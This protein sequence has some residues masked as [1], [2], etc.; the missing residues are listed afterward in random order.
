M[1]LS[2]TDFAS[3]FAELLKTL[4]D[5][6]AE[7]FGAGM[8]DELLALVPDIPDRA[9]EARLFRELAVLEAKR[10]ELTCLDHAERALAAHADTG[11]LSDH[12]LY[13]MHLTCGDVGTAWNGGPRTA[14]HL[15]EALRLHAELGRPLAEAFSLRLNRG[16]HERTNGTARMGLDWFEPLLA[17][18]EREYG[19]DSPYLNHLLGLM[20][21]SEEKMGNMPGALA[22][23]ERALTL[24]DV[25]SDM[26]RRVSAL[27]AHAK[28]QLRAGY[29]D[30]AR[31]L[32]DE[33]ITFADAH[34]SRATQEFAREQ[35]AK[36]F[37]A[38]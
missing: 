1:D 24:L 27:T 28:L 6:N 8:R 15:T 23:A 30:R 21:G 5:E 26:G 14:F 4:D 35:K 9:A 22:H 7:F 10:D 18:G 17:D 33:A 19:A 29:E 2:M 11:A 25:G 34:C 13:F 38:S 37:P 31:Q 3:R 36:I 16:V 12:R 20:S 32:S